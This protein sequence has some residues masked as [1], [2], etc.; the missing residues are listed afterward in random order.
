MQYRFG[1]SYYNKL[2]LALLSLNK[3]FTFDLSYYLTGWCRYNS[4]SKSGTQRRK[5][6]SHIRM[7]N[8]VEAEVTIA[9]DNEIAAGSGTPSGKDLHRQVSSLQRRHSK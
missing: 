8:V 2:L 1:L 7:G 5:F 9:N 3:S 6:H 4:Y